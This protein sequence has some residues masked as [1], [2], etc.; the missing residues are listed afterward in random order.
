MVVDGGTYTSNGTGSPAVYVTADISIKDATLTAN[1]SEGICIEG[2]NTLRLFNCDLTSS[3]PDND[4]NDCTWSVILYQSMSGDSEVGN[5]SFY[6]VDGSITS[7]NGGL[8]YSTNTESDFYLEN[9]TITASDDC[10]FFLKVTGNQNER[11]W[12]TVGENGADTDFTAVNQV[13]SGD[14]IWD[15]VSNLDFY[16]TEGSSLTGAIIDDETNAGDG[17]DG[18][19]SVY[20]DSTSTWI[21]T[22]DSTVTNLYSEGTITDEEGN[23]VTI[24]DSDG[25]IYVEGTSEYTITVEEYSEEVD[26]S[27]VLTAPSWEDYEVEAPSALDVSTDTTSDSSDTESTT[28]ETTSDSSVTEATVE[29]AES[30]ATEAKSTSTGLIIGIVVVAA[31]VIGA[32]VAVF[33]KKN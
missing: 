6:M 17:G 28:E 3:M 22:G 21:V 29:E 14:V 5:S 32:V 24:E 9:V 33:N 1:G 11:G 16:I 20:I 7:T 30:T 2:L 25:T 12:G 10:E 19:C 8:F 31:L 27:G 15:S 4:Q 18:Y 13:M 26:L 23:T